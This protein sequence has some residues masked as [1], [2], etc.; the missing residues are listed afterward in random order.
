[1]ILRCRQNPPFVIR[2]LQQVPGGPAKN[3]FNLIG[4]QASILAL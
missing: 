1:M 2:L 4:K 3:V